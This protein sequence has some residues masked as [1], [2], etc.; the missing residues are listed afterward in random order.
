M[1]ELNNEL[2]VN[3][4]KVATALKLSEDDS[5]TIEELKKQVERAWSMV[6][7]A[8]AREEAANSNIEKLQEEVG[9]LTASLAKHQA[10]LGADTSLEDLISARDALAV[11]LREA[12]GTITKERDRADESM[13]EL[14]V[15]QDKYKE[16]KAQI[17][18][19]ERQLAAKAAEE[20]RD[21]KRRA[22]LEAEAAH[23]RDQLAA[24]V[25]AA[26][27]LKK[28]IEEAEEKNASL[29]KQLQNQ[30]YAMTTSLNDFHK[31]HK[32]M[33]K[34]AADLEEQVRQVSL[35][36]EE[37][38]KLEKETRLRAEEASR[39]RANGARLQAKLDG[40]ARERERVA[41]MLDDEKVTAERLKAEVDAL[42]KTL[43]REHLRAKAT[44]RT[45]A[46]LDREKSA[47]EKKVTVEVGKAAEARSDM[48]AKAEELAALEGDNRRLTM[49]ATKM[50]T[51][52]SVLE[53]DRERI[54]AQVEEMEKRWKD[55][56][57]D[58]RAREAA[59]GDMEKKEAELSNRLKQ[60]Q[61]AYEALRTEKTAVAKDLLA[62]QDE[63]AE[64][65]RK[66]KVQTNQIEQL[67]DDIHAKDRALVAE[68]FVRCAAWA[69]TR[70][71]ARAPSPSV[72]PLRHHHC[73]RHHYCHHCRHHR[74]PRRSTNPWRSGW[75]SARTRW[76]S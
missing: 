72:T 33:A 11:R 6:E 17:K 50:R 1:K 64:L 39:E 71:R 21:A 25:Q 16:K 45:V 47:V 13:K 67:K 3:A 12:E 28:V 60:S 9:S 27:A 75:S 69:R 57:E 41:R 26:E 54:R 46:R 20:A 35:L 15:K 37:K 29:E 19:L 65:K 62:A 68:E 52:I 59:L 32:D 49:E 51:V 40:E 2:V 56:Q 31:L 30:R 36:K 76:S 48:E 66:S 70:A 24:R 73:R 8:N 53:R 74:H 42:E 44:E 4:G 10:L 43:D 18:E 22:N 5:S 55:S 38:V 14:A 61:S 58:V 23:L 7:G 63:I 34:L